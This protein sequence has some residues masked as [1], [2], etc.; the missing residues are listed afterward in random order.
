M[1][2]YIRPTYLGERTHYGAY[3]RLSNLK[4]RALDYH[5]SDPAPATGPPCLSLCA[6][7]GFLPTS[8]HRGVCVCVGGEPWVLNGNYR[9]HQYSLLTGLH[10]CSACVQHFCTLMSLPLP[11]TSEACHQLYSSNVSHYVPLSLQT[12]SCCLFQ[13]SPTVAFWTLPCAQAGPLH[14]LSVCNGVI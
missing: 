14:L 9:P 8:C 13:T 3:R 11:V 5:T 6:R 7:R 4:N 12:R 10:V 1:Y 2:I